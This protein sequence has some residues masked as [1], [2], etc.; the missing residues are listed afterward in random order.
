M[1]RT[2]QRPP[3]ITEVDLLEVLTQRTHLE[4]L[5]KQV[6]EAEA[7][8]EQKE[9]E[10]MTLLKLGARVEGYRT[11]TI[12]KCI[13]PHR[14][15]YQELWVEHMGR[16]HGITEAMSMEVARNTYPPKTVENL[17]IGE[18]YPGILDKQQGQC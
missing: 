18:A 3:I 13:G 14:P 1:K 4:T 2:V 8:L 9:G 11:A 12:E 5:R 15:K 16:Y 10:V 6:R 7:K 17:V